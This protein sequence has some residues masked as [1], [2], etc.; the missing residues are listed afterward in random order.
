MPSL[1]KELTAAELIAELRSVLPR[2]EVFSRVLEERVCESFVSLD[3]MP[4]TQT[5]LIQ[6]LLDHFTSDELI[7]DFVRIYNRLP[8]TTHLELRGTR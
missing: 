1:Q 4:A 6:A 2:E 8:R 5:G 7:E 3:G